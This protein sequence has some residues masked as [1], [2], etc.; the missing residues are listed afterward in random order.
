M[1][2]MNRWYPCFAMLLAMAGLLIIAQ[3]AFAQS[4][5]SYGDFS[6]SGG[7]ATGTLYES[8]GSC[9]TTISFNNIF[10]FII[11]NME[12]LSSNLLGNMFC[13]MITTL[14]PAVVAVL[15]IAVLVFG[16]GFT[17]GVIPATAREFQIFLIKIAF[18]LVFATQAD[19]L[20]GF[21]YKF[22]ITG[23]RDS[24]TTLVTSYLPPPPEGAGTSVD[25]YAYLDRF[26]AQTIRYATDYVG[27]KNTDAD[28]CKDAIFAVLAL[29]AVA[30]PP[31]TYLSLLII[32]KIALTF[33][34]AVF[35]YVYALVGISFLLTLAPFFLS[36]FLFRQTRALFDKWLGYIVSFTLQIVLLFAF[37]VFTVTLCMNSSNITS[38][39][40][41]IIIPKAYQETPEGTTFRLPWEYCTICEFKAVLKDDPGTEIVPDCSGRDAS[42]GG[43]TATCGYKDFIQKG[44]LVC[45]DDPPKP[46]P[47]LAAAAPEG[48][49]APSNKVVNSLLKFTFAGLA[50][51]AVLAYIVDGLLRYLPSMAQYLA[52]GMGATYAPQ[53]GGGKNPRGVET[54]D[55]PLLG[56]EDSGVVKD[57]G[58]GFQRGF[59][60][61][62]NSI[63]AMAQGLKA[64]AEN[65]TSGTITVNGRTTPTGGGMGNHFMHWLTDP[66]RADD[67]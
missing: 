66:N 54:V 56:R 52:G 14:T 53:L 1:T 64:G 12:Q 57:F 49:N 39:F 59:S 13:G 37:L 19:Y 44:K 18:V 7:T 61:G 45:K 26:V 9:P 47:A 46:I 36:F 23:V 32:A 25:A 35:G 34:R 30:F 51:I 48:G 62:N 60:A 11:C 41:D 28:Y 63:T 3:P 6:C 29:M 16:L 17:I 2:H 5:G 27:R 33:L 42:D 55:I 50:S 21:G 38:S 43:D 67:N 31:M 4:F 10:S 40:A 15:T 58:D 8:R 24:V 20:I 65:V 22:L